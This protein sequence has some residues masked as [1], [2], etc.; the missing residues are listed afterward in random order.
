ML[1][2]GD[3]LASDELVKSIND[4]SLDIFEDVSKIKARQNVV[5]SPFRSTH[6]RLA[7]LKVE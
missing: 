7:F 2:S 4:F 6:K 1:F 3:S 5:L